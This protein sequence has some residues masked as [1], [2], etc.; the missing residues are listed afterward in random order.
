MTYTI[1]LC[2]TSVLHFTDLPGHWAIA[3]E[4]LRE[5]FLSVASKITEKKVPQRERQ[6]IKVEGIVSQPPTHTCLLSRGR[7][8][9][10]GFECTNRKKSSAP[11]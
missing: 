11:G 2:E 3:R 1:L 9:W 6:P 4:E 8:R 7:E 5:E 10:E